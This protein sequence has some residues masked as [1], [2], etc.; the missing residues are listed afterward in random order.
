MAGGAFLL[1]Y[2]YDTA[3]VT[4]Y[5]GR[6]IA[7][8]AIDETLFLD[9]EGGP[10]GFLAAKVSGRSVGVPGVVDMLGKAHDDHGV[11]D[12]SGLFEDAIALS[13][14]GFEVSPR[15]AQSLQFADRFGLRDQAE[16]KAYFSDEDGNLLAA[17][18]LLR[19]PGYAEALR[20]LSAN[21]R[22]FYEAP[23]ATQMI[24]AAQAEPHPSALT[25]DDFAFY[26]AARAEPLCSD[27]RDYEICGHPMP[28]SGGVAVIQ[29]ME[30]IERTG[31]ANAPFDTPENLARFAEAQRLA[32]AD[33]E[34]FAADDRKVAVPVDALVSDRYLDAR[35]AEITPGRGADTVLAGSPATIEPRGIVTETDSPGT[36]HFVVVDAEGNVVSMTTSVESIFGSFRMAGGMILNNQLTDFTFQPVDDAGNPTANR[37]GPGKHPRS[38]MSPTIVL[39]KDGHFLMATGSPGGSS[40]IA[41]T[42]KS[43]LGVLDFAMT[44]QEAADFPNLVA[45][46]TVRVEPLDETQGWSEALAE[47]GFPTGES[48]GENSGI[49]TVLV[50]ENG[51]VGAADKR[52]EGT[53]ATPKSD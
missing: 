18:H 32:Y 53:I 7:P 13:E 40:I 45:R 41:Y 20:A 36:S 19:N 47:R 52:R 28:T 17:G 22:A 5:N 2:D 15:M 50:T 25:L 11:L 26:E 14:E 34:K 16:L 10:M 8:M 48:R 51:L 38:S 43:L 9:D 29:I 35:A 30:L 24:A 39:D 4:A 1:H 33:R 42:T 46:G 3:S 27:F 23:I 49:H 12:W 6:E 44:P 37:P 31:W 21:Q